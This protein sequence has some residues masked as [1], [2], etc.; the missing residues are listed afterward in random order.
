M[1]Y[2]LR[3][4]LEVRKILEDFPPQAN[5]DSSILTEAY[6]RCLYKCP[7]LQCKRFFSGFATGHERDEHVRRHERNHKCTINDCDY[8]ELGFASERELNKHIQL[9]HST[10]CEDFKFPDVGPVST[11]KALEDAIDR[12]DALAIRGICVAQTAHTI[13]ETGFLL[14]AFKKRNLNAAMVVMELLGIA[15]EVNHRDKSGRTAFHE[16]MV[17]VEFEILLKEILNSG[18]D[19]QAE[20]LSRRNPLEKALLGGHFHAVKSLLSIDGINLKSCSDWAIRKGVLKAA[21]EGKTEVLQTVFPFAVSAIKY[22]RLSE[23]ISAVF[24]HAAFHNHESTVSLILKLGQSTGIEEHYDSRLQEE[25]PK[26]LEAVTKLLMKRAVDPDPEVGSKGKTRGSR[27]Q[28]AA[29]KGDSATVISLLEKGANIDHGSKSSL[30][31]LAYA[32]RASKLKMM[33][34]LLDRG[35]KVDAPSGKWVTPLGAASS[36]G[37]V[38][39][40]ELLLK[41]GADSEYGVY[42]ASSEGQYAVVELLLQ[43]GAYVNAHGACGDALNVACFGGHEEVVKLLL[44]NRAGIYALGEVAD[45]PFGEAWSNELEDYAYRF[46]GGLRSEKRRGWYS[47]LCAA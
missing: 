40:V 44:K 11:S 13:T 2:P 1:P 43:N 32:S 33:Q 14:R 39:A 3:R 6:G 25:L 42:P 20:C 5:S 46:R 8:S 30:T 35:A 4:L 31:A 45:V 9:C 15:S 28:H 22:G 10:S 27:L 17:D 34:L 38:A 41:N 16:A 26:G 47:A 37:H 18:F 7:I 21:A 19:V 29:E 36:K 23:W 24:N 12:N